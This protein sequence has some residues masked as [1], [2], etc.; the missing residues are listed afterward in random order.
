MKF[1]CAIGLLVVFISCKQNLQSEV[2]PDKQTE[3]VRIDTMAQNETE[4]EDSLLRFSD[5]LSAYFEN[6]FDF[7]SL[8][9]KTMHMHTGHAPEFKEEY[10]LK[11]ENPYDQ[12][13]CY[14]ALEFDIKK[15]NS[16]KSLVFATWKPWA[17]HDER[18]YENDNEILVGLRS[19]ISWPEGLQRSDFVGQS[20]QEIK[21][22]FGE[23]Q[24]SEENCLLY[25]Q[26]EK[27][28]M[29]HQKNEKV[30]WFKFFVL[31]T[32]EV[33]LEKLPAEFFEFS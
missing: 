20:V 29:F 4:R 6:P 32:N 27:L 9:Q 25:F 18:D 12:F 21:K 33:S 10:F 15:D 17:S 22:R 19:K 23:P 2:A 1:L 3:V 16:K 28:L 7:Y 24:Q 14:W 31:D 8:K 13:Y 30:D 11:T 26:N 5:S